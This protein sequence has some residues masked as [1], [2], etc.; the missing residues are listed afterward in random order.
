MCPMRVLVVCMANSVRSP[1]LAALL[2]AERPSWTVLSAGALDA[3]AGRPV[4]PRAA[5]S[6]AHL[7]LPP[8][9]PSRALRAEDGADCELVLFADRAARDWGGRPRFGRSRP[10]EDYFDPEGDIPDPR[11][12]PSLLPLLPAWRRAAAAVAARYD[13]LAA[14]EPWTPGAGDPHLGAPVAAFARN[15]HHRFHERVPGTWHGWG[16]DGGP[17]A[18]FDPPVGGPVGFGPA[19][20]EPHP[21]ALD[22]LRLRRSGSLR[23]ADCRAYALAA[24]PPIGEAARAIEARAT[25][26]LRAV[27]FGRL[28]RGAAQFMAVPPALDEIM[29]WL[30][31]ETPA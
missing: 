23:V 14:A 2:A 5:E 12:A 24:G 1:V 25:K 16:E 18:V 30:A 28:A 17:S 10:S 4:D 15:Y 19:G 13:G 8:P 22:D 20:W 7:G 27:A 3:L 31:E 9:P 29:A 11:G 26:E 6:V 21:T